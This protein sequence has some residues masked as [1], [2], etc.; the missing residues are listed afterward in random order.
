L[1]LGAHLTTN[2]T[3]IAKYFVYGSLVLYA[4][5]H[6]WKG[7]YVYNALERVLY[8]I[9]EAIAITIFSLYLF[10]VEDMVKYELDFIG[11]AVIL[12]LDIIFI[13][14][15]LISWLVYGK[16]DVANANQENS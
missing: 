14:L 3:E 7:I 8:G 9:G 10:D 15:R 2:K 5:L 13:I 4:T 6:L 12:L 1:V 16:T 11:L